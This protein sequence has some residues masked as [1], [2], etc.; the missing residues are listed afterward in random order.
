MMKVVT[1]LLVAMA[2]SKLASNKRSNRTL[3]DM[4]LSFINAC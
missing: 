4:L 1:Q 3:K 2:T